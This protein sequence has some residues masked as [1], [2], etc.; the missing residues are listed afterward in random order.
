MEI[1]GR[2]AWE[3]RN[4][5]ERG[6]ES[7][8]SKI[9]FRAWGQVFPEGRRFTISTFF[10]VFFLYHVLQMYHYSVDLRFS[11][12]RRNMILHFVCSILKVAWKRDNF[13]RWEETI[14]RLLNMFS[15]L[16]VVFDTTSISDRSLLV[17]SIFEERIHKNR[18]KGISNLPRIVD[19]YDHYDPFLH[20]PE[21]KKE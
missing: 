18:S 14:T 12:I 11:S 21:S 9:L 16:I 7:L 6:R 1:D 10:L 3:N 2:R 17:L 5:R 20:F 15:G 13:D 4:R 19:H 8:G